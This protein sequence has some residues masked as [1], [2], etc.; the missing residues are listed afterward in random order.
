[1][2]RSPYLHL[3][4]PASQG[5]PPGSS[6]KPSVELSGSTTFTVVSLAAAPAALRRGTSSRP[7]PPAGPTSVGSVARLT[8]RSAAPGAAEATA[9]GREGAGGG[10]TE[11]EGRARKR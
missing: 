5:Q 10:V 4:A 7:V 3:R 11:R 6:P 2:A 9:P 8:T 1:A